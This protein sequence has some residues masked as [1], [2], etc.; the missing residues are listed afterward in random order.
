MKKCVT[1]GKNLGHWKSRYCSTDC[2]DLAIRYYRYED[3]VKSTV[4]HGQCT[5]KVRTKHGIYK[6]PNEGLSHKEGMCFEC[7]NWN[8]LKHDIYP[9]KDNATRC[10]EL[11]L[12]L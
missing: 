3:F 7:Y 2:S 9:H 11:Y 1:C 12:V 8:L 4:F 6:C 5:E 10:T